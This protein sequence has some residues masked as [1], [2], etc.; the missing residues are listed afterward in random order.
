MSS[1]MTNLQQTI[2]QNLAEAS[3]PLPAQSGCEA[4]MP[5]RSGTQRRT[6]IGN[7]FGLLLTCA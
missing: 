4:V 2:P 7:E 3:G 6:G 5:A 1:S